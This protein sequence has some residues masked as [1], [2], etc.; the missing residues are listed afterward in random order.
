MRLRYNKNAI[1]LL[2]NSEFCIKEFPYKISNNTVLEIGMGKGR[3]LANLAE[4]NPN[5]QYIG[6]EKYSTPAL[7]ALKKIEAKKLKNM[8]IIV[9]DAIQLDSYFD[10]KIKTIWLTFSDPWP[11][12]R[13]FKRRLVYKTFLEQYKKILA[14]D[15]VV[16]F[17]TDNQLL[18][19][20]ALEQLNE[21]N[22]N[23]LYNTNDLHHCDYEIDNQLT[24]YEEKFKNEGKNIY[25]IA[26][27][28]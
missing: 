6:L 22:A 3:M 4:K 24:D 16:Y 10:G 5:I 21:F 26:F 28:F 15:G 25:F 20:F 9:N 19:E 8:K 14:K 27:N 18:Y 2:E 13:H 23:V 11:K 12:K 1:N 7:S 17:K